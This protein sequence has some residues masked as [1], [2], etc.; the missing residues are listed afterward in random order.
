MRGS[1]CCVGGRQQLQYG[2]DSISGDFKK[3]KLAN[4][5]IVYMYCIDCRYSLFIA[6]ILLMQYVS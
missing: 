3:Q 1:V 4:T 6:M 5:L 2:V